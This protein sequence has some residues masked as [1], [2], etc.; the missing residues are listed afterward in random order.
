MAYRS[1]VH[2][3]DYMTGPVIQWQ[4]GLIHLATILSGNLTTDFDDTA[5][6]LVTS[7]II[8]AFNASSNISMTMDN[9]AT[10][11]TNYFRDSSNV[12]VVGKGGEVETYVHVRWLWIT[13]PAFLILAGT[14][15]LILAI[16]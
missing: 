7:N 15:F 1:Q 2:G 4:V 9:I 6:A 10:L 5:S 14:L 3:T 8:G 11:M 12:T 16:F 13:L